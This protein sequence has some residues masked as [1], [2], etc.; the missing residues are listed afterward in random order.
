[1]ACLFAARLAA[2][3]IK[4]KM[5]GSWQD[6]LRALRTQGVRIIEAD[7]AEYTYKVAVTSDPEQCGGLVL[8]WF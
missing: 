3:G 1:M 6:G 8:L 7:G 4:V 2:I 5:L